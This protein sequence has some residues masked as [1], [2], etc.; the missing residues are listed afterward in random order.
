[1][2]HN[3]RSA[4]EVLDDHLHESNEGTIDDDLARNFAEDAIFLTS[5]GVLHGH[6][7]IRQLNQRLQEELPGAT[8]EYHNKLVV[9][10]VDFLEWTARTDDAVIE[11]GA[12]T[13]VIRG[14]RIIAQTIHYTVT[15]T[16]SAQ[17]QKHKLD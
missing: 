3:A 10:K 4:K 14:G 2:G 1:M 12:D 16:P 7:G 6:D 13:Y 9:G 8:Y 17:A 11:D 15:R 5:Y